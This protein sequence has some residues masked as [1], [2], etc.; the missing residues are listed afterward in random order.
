MPDNIPDNI[1]KIS[2]ADH[3]WEFADAVKAHIGVSII[4][5]L[6][7]YDQENF[8]KMADDAKDE[9]Q[10][11]YGRIIPDINTAIKN[12]CKLM[13][14]QE[15][16]S[17]EA[18]NFDHYLKDQL[19]NG[20]YQ[21]EQYY[22]LGDDE[23]IGDTTRAAKVSSDGTSGAK[24]GNKRYRII[25]DP[26]TKLPLRDGNKTSLATYHMTVRQAVSDNID[27]EDA[28][29][30]RLD[31]QKEQVAATQLEKQMA[32]KAIYNQKRLYAEGE[33]N[34]TAEKARLEKEQIQQTI[35]ASTAAQV[36]S[37]KIQEENNLL[38]AAQKSSQ[39]IR[40]NADAQAYANAKL[41]Q[42]GLTP[43]ERAEYD[44]KRAIGVAAELAK[45]KF[46]ETLFMGGNDNGGDGLLSKLLGADLARQL[47][48]SKQQ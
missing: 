43:Q 45:I 33:A 39:I 25:E 20:S 4:I 11:L 15:Y 42:A 44:N 27:W 12:T 3:Q 10:L 31:K 17:G 34:K 46:P 41:V 32:E 24:K 36:A 38:A 48:A 7:P 26:K 16:I 28:F 22:V 29:D 1:Y 5:S 2:A 30:I 8:S 40:V 18:A 21:L 9:K 6:N 35:S 13:Y 23:N 37:F 19:E 47:K 14:A